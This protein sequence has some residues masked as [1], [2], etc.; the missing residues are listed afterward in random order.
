[1]STPDPDPDVQATSEQ[2]AQPPRVRQQP[3][4]PP[5]PAPAHTQRPRTADAAASV[6]MAP[7]AEGAPRPAVH[8]AAAGEL[9]ESPRRPQSAPERRGP[10]TRPTP[11]HPSPEASPTQQHLLRCPETPS[12]GWA[13]VSAQYVSA[14]SPAAWILCTAACLSLPNKPACEG[15]GID[16]CCFLQSPWQALR[17]LQVAPLCV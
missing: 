10:Q 13:R 9:V 17:L 11:Q 5:A 16:W 4:A 3:S 2:Q 12:L 15:W 1:M 7:A 6:Q 14:A 8:F